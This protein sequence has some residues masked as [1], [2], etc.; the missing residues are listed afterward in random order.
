MDKPLREA[1]LGDIVA[2]FRALVLTSADRELLFELTPERF[3]PV[4]PS[5]DPIGQGSRA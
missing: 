5:P 4:R 3:A 1:T 2:H